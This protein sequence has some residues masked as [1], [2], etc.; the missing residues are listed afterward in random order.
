VETGNPGLLFLWSTPDE[1]FDR[2]RAALDPAPGS[3]ADRVIETM[4]QT[5]FINRLFM[6]GKNWESNHV[7]ATWMKRSMARHLDAARAA[8]EAEPRVLVKLGANH[9]YRGLNQTRQY[10]VGT[11][12]AQVAEAEGSRSFHL[13]VVGGPGTRASSFNPVTMTYETEPVGMLSVVLPTQ[14][15]VLP[16][17]WTLFDFRPLRAAIHNREVDVTQ[18]MFDLAFNFDALLVMTGSTPARPWFDPGAALRR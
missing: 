2:L 11:M 16:D 18:E 13:L 14:R 7:R 3:R 5:S 15:L 9:T 1:P 17:A 10:D 4:Q 8:G 6:T 12:L